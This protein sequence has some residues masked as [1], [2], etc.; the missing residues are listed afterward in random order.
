MND[1]QLFR[2]LLLVGFLPVLPLGVFHRLQAYRA[3]GAV[4]RRAEGTFILLTLRPIAGC[5]VLG[6][7]AYL[8]DPAWMAWSAVPLHAAVR[9]A[10]VLC[11][12]SGWA[13]LAWTFH[14][15]GL[16]LTDTVVTRAEHTLVTHGP[17]RRV[18]HPLYTAVLLAFLGNALAAAN[19][20][21]FATGALAFA[22]LVLRTD[23]EEAHL[24][25]R[26]GGAY[27]AYIQRTGRF[28]PRLS[29]HR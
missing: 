5:A 26:F 8:V 1:D 15:L 10:G 22:L 12:W 6:S 25:A 18:R 7:I 24:V 27:E 9:A 17:Y 29:T 16:N 11:S 21:L 23:R 4:S 14:A 20:F 28:L 2:L 3:G 13:L 19:W